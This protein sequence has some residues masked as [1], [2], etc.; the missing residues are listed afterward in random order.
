[1]NGDKKGENL[2]LAF[3]DCLEIINYSKVLN[4]KEETSDVFAPP[5][6]LY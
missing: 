3:F 5:I 4:S 1:V 6:M 2:I